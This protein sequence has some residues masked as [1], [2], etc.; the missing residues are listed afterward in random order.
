MRPSAATLAREFAAL[1][2]VLVGVA[3][4]ESR[5]PP[6]GP[7]SLTETGAGEPPPVPS[8]R[9]LPGRRVLVG[10]AIAAMV[11][12]GA[13]VT[14]TFTS[15]TPWFTGAGASSTSCSVAYRLKETWPNGATV[16]LS[17]A[18]TGTTGI[19]GWTLRFDLKEGLQARSGWNGRWQ[20]HGTRVTVA[21]TPDNANL[22]PGTSTGDV[23]TNIDGQ[24]ATSVPDGFLLNGTRCRTDPPR[25]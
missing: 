5:P 9:G 17:I 13:G 25:S 3:S 2:G 18:N 14:A 1:A 24:D 19:K 16:L 8:Q 21:D 7:R 6:T 11:L 23:G 4:S 12:A 15:R 10:I 20:Q 22:A